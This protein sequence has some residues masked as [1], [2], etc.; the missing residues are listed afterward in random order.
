M[1]N[2]DIEFRASGTVDSSVVDSSNSRHISGLAIA[3]GVRSGLIQGLFYETIDPAA[4]NNQ[5][6]SNNDI[7]LYMNHDEAEGTYARSKFGKGTL[8]LS[9]TNRGLEFSADL[10]TTSQGD[11][12]LE[13]IRRGDIDAMSFAFIADDDEW[14][15]N[16]DGTYD[17]TI[18]SFSMIDEISVLSCLPAYSATDVAL[19]SLDE[20]KKSKE[21]PAEKAGKTTQNCVYSSYRKVD[22]PAE[23]V[24]KPAEPKPAKSICDDDLKNYY[25]EIEKS[26]E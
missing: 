6:I 3:T 13:G 10:P 26:L 7:K 22:K 5:L 18:H 25:D 9:V 8:Q 4:I 23:I 17:R 11:N 14:K 12:V 19:R 2:K 1:K 16:G 21:K 20:F 24:D 15:D